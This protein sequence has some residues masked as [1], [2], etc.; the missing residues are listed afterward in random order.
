MTT[1]GTEKNR[2][3][4]NADNKS[5]PPDQQILHKTDPQDNMEGPVSSLMH[6][7]G[8]SFETDETQA[9]ADLEKEKNM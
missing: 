8:K 1:D 3:K 9:E 7:A 6:K 5:L 4:D 2:S